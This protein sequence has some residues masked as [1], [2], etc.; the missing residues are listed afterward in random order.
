MSEFYV[1]LPQ[2][3]EEAKEKPALPPKSKKP[4]VRFKSAHSTK[5]ISDHSE[6]S[7][8]QT[9]DLSIKPAIPKNKPSLPKVSIREIDPEVDITRN[10]SGLNEMQIMDA[11]KKSCNPLP[12]KQVY[13]FFVSTHYF[14][15]FR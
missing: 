5:M 11:I 7:P 10:P 15:N 1:P 13:Q 4:S 14:C 12:I 6:S 8:M 9:R 2:A 3:N